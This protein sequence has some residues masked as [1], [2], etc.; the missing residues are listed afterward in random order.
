[1]NANLIDIV[2]RMPKAELHIH[3]EGSLEPE[4]LFAMAKR[5]G[6]ALAHGSVESLRQ[7]YAFADLQSFLDIYYAGAGVLLTERDFYDMTWAYLQR[8]RAD[9]VRHVEMFF[10]PQ[11]HTSRGVDFSTVIHGIH[12]ALLDAQ[13]LLGISGGLIMCFLRHLPEEE[14]FATLELALPH[15]E[16]SSASVLILPSA[17]IRRS[18]LRGCLHAARRWDYVWWRMPAKRVRRPT[19]GPRSMCLRSSGSTMA[20]AAWKMPH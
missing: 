20:C 7:A 3:I 15:R 17:G 11:T 2:Q 16:N 4:L 5:N 14:A 18:S 10:D 9:N 6:V 8:A 19:F 1:M 13:T 12:R